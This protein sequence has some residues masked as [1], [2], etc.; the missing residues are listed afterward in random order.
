MAVD[1]FSE[2][3]DLLIPADYET[4]DKIKLGVWLSTQRTKYK[5]NKLSQ[6][7][8]ERLDKIGMVWDP[9]D[10]AWREGYKYAL[11]YFS[12]YGNL[13]MRS[14]YVCDDGFKLYAWI[15]NKRIAYAKGRLSKERIE[16]LEQLGMRWHKE[17][18][19]D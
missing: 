2:H 11:E 19:K 17:D 14:N 12:K 4:R 18:R 6:N 1:Y 8:I 3:G 10:Q 9:Y 15:Q 7:Q 5:G 13:N 16:L